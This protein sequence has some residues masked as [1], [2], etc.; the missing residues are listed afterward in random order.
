M[1]GLLN[2]FDK[3]HVGQVVE[4]AVEKIEP[5]RYQ[6][7]LHFDEDELRQLA[8]S[9]RQHGLITPITVRAVADHYEI[10]AGERRLKAA[11]LAGL[12]KLTC[13]I[14]SPDEN[15]AAQMALIENIQR[16]DLSAVEEARGYVQIMRQAGLT[17]AQVAQK[18]GKSQSA[19]A[20]K[21]RLLNLSAEVQQGVI[22]QNI[23]ERHAR[24]L[25][26]LPPE[27]Q[28]AV[29]RQF[30]KKKM[31]SNAERKPKSAGRRPEALHEIF[32]SALIHWI[33]ACACYRRWVSKPR[34]KRKIR[35]KRRGSSSAFRNK[36]CRD[37]KDYRSCQSKRRGRENDDK[38]Q[39]RGRSCL[40][41]Q[42][43]FAGGF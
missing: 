34:W 33:S 28:T 37:G 12:R 24:A 42:P 4:I 27:K 38:H 20:N 15:Q 5:S 11:R 21:I 6:P 18:V 16:A 25:L 36:R 13:Y 2:L 30:L 9:I 22:E 1:A 31:K 7:R 14:L 8:D 19:V 17:Q 29:Y 35:P 3:N 39:S 26:Q 41:R 10:V 43:C 40:C 23:S 32:R